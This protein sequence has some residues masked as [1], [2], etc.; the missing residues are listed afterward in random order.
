MAR[1]IFEELMKRSSGLTESVSFDHKSAE[2]KVESRKI[3]VSNIKV[4]SRKIFEDTD[5]DDLDQQFANTDEVNDDEVV[6]VIDPELPSDEEPAENA[7]EE[8][9]GDK[10]YKCPICGSN[11]VCDCDAAQEESIEVDENGVPVECPICGD[12]AD[13]I[14]IGE[15][16]PAEDA[17]EES[18]LDP[19]K[20]EDEDEAVP[21]DE[22]VEEESLKESTSMS[23]KQMINYLERRYSK[24]ENADRIEAILSRIYGSDDFPD[25]DPKE[26]MWAN[27]TDEQLRDAINSFEGYRKVESL[28]EDFAEDEA[29]PE[30]D[31]C[32]ECSLELAAPVEEPKEEAPAVVIKDSDVSLTLDDARF[33]SLMTKMIKENYNNAPKFKLSKVSMSSKSGRMRIE[34]FIKEGKKVSKGVLIGEGFNKD[35]RVSRINFVD[36]GVFTESFAKTPSFIVECVLIKGSVRPVA[37]SYDYKVKVNEQF[38]RVK[39]KVSK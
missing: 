13:Q 7:A 9:I 5:Y 23:R 34:Y 24:R 27:F 21:E 29:V 15:I 35:K 33:E 1:S 32:P 38:Y 39:G 30:C 37:I 19:V 26:G 3:K 20:P 6:L 12:D 14:L 36:Q 31:E 17:G 22:E 11:Y 10:V 16:T 2:K 18:E 28:K 4:E 25:D 8:M